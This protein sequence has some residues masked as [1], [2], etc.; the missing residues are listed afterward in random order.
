MEKGLHSLLC[1]LQASTEVIKFSASCFV[2]TSAKSLVERVQ[3][4]LAPLTKACR[5]RD[6]RRCNV[7]LQVQMEINRF[8]ANTSLVYFL[9]TMGVAATREAAAVHDSLVGRAFHLIV[10]DAQANG[11]E[12][13][14]AEAQARLPVRLGGC[15]LT[16][17]ASIADAACVGS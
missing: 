2:V 16:A 13:Q 17:Q 6:T 15:G 7:A 11:G 5:L 4:Q 12:Q 9:R 1:H 8:C 14:R 10:G 3:A